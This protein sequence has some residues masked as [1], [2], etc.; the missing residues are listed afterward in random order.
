MGKGRL[1]NYEVLQQPLFVFKVVG[2]PV[3]PADLKRISCFPPF[4]LP[5]RFD[6]F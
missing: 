6:F 2:A 5:P 4:F 1:Q 3:I